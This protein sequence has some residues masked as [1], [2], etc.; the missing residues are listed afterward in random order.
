MV[1]RLP[2]ERS[3][4]RLSVPLKCIIYGMWLAGH[5]VADILA[6]IVKPDGSTPSEVAVRT[7]ISFVAASGGIYWSGVTEKHGGGRPRST[8]VALDKKIVKTVFKHRGKAKVT[9]E[10]LRKVIPAARRIPTRTLSRRLADAGLAWLRRRRKTLVSVQYK[11]ARMAWAAWVNARQ[12]STLA[13]WMYTDGTTFYLARTVPESD[14]KNRLALG[15][16]VYR[17]AD[18]S[19]ALFEDC[20]GP[21]SYAK[22]QGMQVRMWGLLLNG[23]LFLYFLPKGEAMTHARYAWI[24]EHKFP[25]WIEKPFGKR[26]KR[27]P[28]LVQDHERA[29]WKE[30]PLQAMQTFGISL[31]KNFPKCSQDLNPIE[32]VWRELRERLYT[33]QPV[34]MESRDDFIARARNAVSWVNK[35]RKGYLKYLCSCQKEWAQ[36]VEDAEGA[37]TKH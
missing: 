5:S 28:F 29:L 31:L 12:A 22:A 7:A 25:G 2:P 21:S 27:I 11:P 35:N 16:H 24:I 19:D 37:R 9:V 6:E 34:E 13:R 18:G 3:H 1:K 10:F 26:F 17:M 33:T 8:N 36:D 4:A 20:V 15:P 23:I 30:G 32:V 14:Q